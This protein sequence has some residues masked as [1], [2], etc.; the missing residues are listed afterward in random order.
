METFRFPLVA[1]FLFLL[2][3]PSGSAQTY[4]AAR[5]F[6]TQSNPNGVWSYG[7]L[8]SPTGPLT[9]YTSGSTC[10]Q[11][12]GISEWAQGP[13]DSSEPPLV[14]HDDT[15]QALCYESWCIGPT[16][17]VLSPGEPDTN[18][19]YSVVRFTAPAS[20]RFLLQ[21]TFAGADAVGPT[22][23]DVHVL[24]D[25]KISLLS[26]PITSYK[27]PMQ[28]A[29]V[30]HLNAGD[31]IDFMVGAGNNSDWHCDSTAIQFQVSTTGTTKAQQGGR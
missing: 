2:S 26:G 11:F 24:L 28:F 23:V 25:G 27:L 30:K 17:L 8:L 12:P 31:T 20:G 16:Y 19:E 3:V 5:D 6:S 21:G 14:R 7:W 15:D 1:V 22:S 29:A 4:D 9:L 13:C 10:N 18:L